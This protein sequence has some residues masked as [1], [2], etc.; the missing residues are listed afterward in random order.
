[1]PLLAFAGAVALLALAAIVRRPTSASWLV[2][3]TFVVSRAVIAAEC[4]GWVL[5]W[6]IEQ[7]W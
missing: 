6:W 1:M 7:R 3:D 2:M 4:A 5:R